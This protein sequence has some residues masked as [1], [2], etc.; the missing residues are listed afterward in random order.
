[1]KLQ[2]HL[3]LLD[4]FR[5]CKLTRPLKH[6]RPHHTPKTM[7]SAIRSV[8]FASSVRQWRFATL[9]QQ[10]A[11]QSSASRSVG[12]ESSLSMFFQLTASMSALPLSRQQPAT[13]TRRFCAP[14]VR[15]R[16]S[17][18]ANVLSTNAQTRK[19]ALRKPRPR[20]RSSSRLLRRAP[21]S[22]PPN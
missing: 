14:F 21:T 15:V 2:L 17:P 10:R 19:V 13:L 11:I 5:N 3:Q 22:G 4:S 18:Q 1:M 16:D 8:R 9:V 12:Q 20:S 7:S 6:R